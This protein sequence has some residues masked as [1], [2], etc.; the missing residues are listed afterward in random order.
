MIKERYLFPLVLLSFLVAGIFFNNTAHGIVIGGGTGFHFF[1]TTDDLRAGVES[2]TRAP[3][4]DQ[5]LINNLYLETYWIG[6]FG[7]G[8]LHNGYFTTTT[9]VE[10]STG[11][12]IEKNFVIN[13][14]FLVAHLVFNFGDSGFW[15]FGLRGGTGKSSYSYSEH[16]E[17]TGEDSIDTDQAVSGSASLAGWFLDGGHGS[18]GF[19]VGYQGVTTTLDNMTVR[20]TSSEIDASGQQLYVDIRWFF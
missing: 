2:Y 14:D 1:S 7:F 16:Y 5:G 13:N 18:I 17:K 12:K 6:G 8:Y 15:R 20:G 19:R 4:A 11:T 10:V 3:E 9:H